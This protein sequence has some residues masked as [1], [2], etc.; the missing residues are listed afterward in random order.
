[1]TTGKELIAYA[2]QTLT[3]SNDKKVIKPKISPREKV[4][5]RLR[6]KKVLVIKNWLN[7]IAKKKDLNCTT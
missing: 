4:F 3:G 1:M 5:K 6:N 2:T 7:R